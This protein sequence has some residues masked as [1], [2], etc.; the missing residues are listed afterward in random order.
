MKFSK[1]I[2]LSVKPLIWNGANLSTHK[3]KQTY[4]ENV[5]GT[6]PAQVMLTGKNDYRFCEHLQADGADELLLQVIHC[7][8][9]FGKRLVI[10]RS[11]HLLAVPKCT[12]RK[13]GAQIG[14]CKCFL[15]I[16]PRIV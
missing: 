6:L 15:E 10:Q 13:K 1:G 4:L 5:T 2:N 9:L 14:F 11:A 12:A 3:F 8:L 16:I 7:L